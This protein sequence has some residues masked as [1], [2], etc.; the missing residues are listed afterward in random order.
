MN[1]N[2]DHIKNKRPSLKVGHNDH[3]TQHKS[4]VWDWK[5]L[6]E[7]ELE[8]KNNPRTKI[9]EPKTPYMPYVQEVVLI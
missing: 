3:D 5:S 1:N 2:N 6:E 7:Q 9:N 4:V 8:R